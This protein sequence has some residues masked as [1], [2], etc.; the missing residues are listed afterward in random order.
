GVGPWHGGKTRLS[1]RSIPG[2]SRIP[3][4]TVSG[5]FPASSAVW[6][7]SATWGPTPSGS[8]RY[9][10]PPT[11][12]TATTSATTGTSTRSTAPWRTWSGSSPRLAAGT[13][14]SSWIWSSTTPP[15]S[16]TGSA[17]AGTKPAPTPTTITGP[18]VG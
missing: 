17:R 3:T 8:P 2:A 15:R 10:A 14:A 1:I 6:T 5:T 11:P 9:T 13:S 18:T 16:I 7:T 4:A 12:T